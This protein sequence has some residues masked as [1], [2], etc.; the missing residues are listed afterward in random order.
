MDICNSYKANKIGAISGAMGPNSLLEHV[1]C[2]RSLV[3]L[4]Q[5]TNSRVLAVI[6]LRSTHPST[7]THEPR[8]T[9]AP[10]QL[11]LNPGLDFV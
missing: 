5:I 6:R 1:L 7:F 10:A 9:L 3:D 2:T 4:Y 8:G 11:R